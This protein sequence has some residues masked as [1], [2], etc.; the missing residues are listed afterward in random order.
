MEN[1][2]DKCLDVV[3]IDSDKEWRG[4]DEPQQNKGKETDLDARCIDD[5]G[6]QSG[7]SND[8]LVPI[9]VD[10]GMKGKLFSYEPDGKIKLEV[11][12][13]FV[14]VDEFRA[15]L[16]D[17]VMQ[18]GFEIQK[19]KNEKARVTA[20]CAAVG[21]GWRIHASPTPDGITYK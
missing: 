5:E 8:E 21:C 11:S 6:R 2:G 1:H 17:F 13:L 18:E 12:L 19:I 14:D 9:Y 15:A 7:N 10:K 16:K 4:G 3:V 20:R